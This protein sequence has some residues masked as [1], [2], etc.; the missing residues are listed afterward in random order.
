MTAKS[1]MG[2]GLGLKTKKIVK[3]TTTTTENPVKFKQYAD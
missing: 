1:N 2:S 3:T